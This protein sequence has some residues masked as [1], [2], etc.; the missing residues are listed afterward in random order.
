MRQTDGQGE[1]AAF[2]KDL[3]E[4]R[5]KFSTGAGS[6]SRKRGGTRGDG[7]RLKFCHVA[8]EPLGQVGLLQFGVVP[9]GDGDGGVELPPEGLALGLPPGWGGPGPAGP[10]GGSSTSPGVEQSLPVG[11]V[12][13]EKGLLRQ[14]LAEMGPQQR[15]DPVLGGNLPPLAPRRN[16]RSGQSPGSAPPPGPSGR[17]PG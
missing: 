13:E 16:R 1:N 3:P 6:G 15:E 10:R 12:V 7:L 9:L 14:P 4:K 8:P 2:W 5:R 17:W 11:F